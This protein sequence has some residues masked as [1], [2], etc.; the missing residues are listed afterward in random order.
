VH[1]GATVQILTA[2]AYSAL[3]PKDANTLYVL[4]G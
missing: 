1:P 2:A 3:T 4:V